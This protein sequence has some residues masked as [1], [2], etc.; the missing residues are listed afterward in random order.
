M[1]FG[2]GYD[3]HVLKK[4]RKLFLGGVLIPHDKGL[5]G[6]SD[7]DCLLH[8]VSDAL[9]G[10]AGLGDIGMHFPDKDPQYKGISSVILLEKTVNM[11]AAR[12]YKVNNIDCVIIA[13]EPKLSSY[14][15]DMINA[16]SKAAGT[17][18]NAVNIKATTNEGV[19]D[20][21]KGKAIAAYAVAS[22]MEK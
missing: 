4:R 16:I 9:L 1:R 20:I 8:A 19:G 3:I 7:A 12:G 6:H 10:A 21:G 11:V 14:Y 22:I 5:L 18:K 15:G 13:E 17:V 2:I